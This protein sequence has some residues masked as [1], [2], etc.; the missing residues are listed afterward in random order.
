MPLV[1]ALWWLGQVG[2]PVDENGARDVPD[3]VDRRG[4]AVGPPPD[5]ENPEAWWQ[6]LSAYLADIDL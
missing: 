1:E 3:R 4:T 5:I 6:A 2:P